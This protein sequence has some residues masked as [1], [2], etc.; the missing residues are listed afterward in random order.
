MARPAVSL[1][2]LFVITAA[3]VILPLAALWAGAP[4]DLD[5]EFGATPGS[6]RQ[7]GPGGYGTSVAA[8]DEGN[9]YVAGCLREGCR[10]FIAQPEQ[11]IINK[12]DSRG[13][14]V[15]SFGT[16][17]RLLLEGAKGM[18]IAFQKEP[19][20]KLLVAAELKVETQPSAQQRF[21]V[22][23]YNL[24]GS[25]DLSF[26]GG[27]GRFE[28]P[29][30]GQATAIALDGD[31]IFAAGKVSNNF[32]VAKLSGNGAP[33][34]TF[35]SNGVATVDGQNDSLDNATSLVLIGGSIYVGGF[36]GHAALYAQNK[37]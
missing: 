34:T 33:V 14:P 36:T 28:I 35:G 5:P 8:D 11:L 24:D 20:R 13:A 21:A 27:L 9:L 1:T 3:A 29:G 32:V 17:G 30:P 18:A 25:P 12:Y 6:G 15:T 37:S 23:R 31:S 10:Y 19:N 26:N 7:I 22:L 4:G 2:A 16:Q